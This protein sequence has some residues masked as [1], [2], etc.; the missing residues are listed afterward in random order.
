[1]DDLLEIPSFIGLNRMGSSPPSP[2]FDFPP[3]SFIAIASDSCDSVDI[4]PRLI[5][6]VANLFTISF[7]NST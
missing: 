2:V 4:E 3:S 5:A 7:S 6:P 1:M